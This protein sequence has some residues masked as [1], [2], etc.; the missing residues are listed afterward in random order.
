MSLRSAVLTFIEKCQRGEDFASLLKEMTDLA[1]LLGFDRFSITNLW[2]VEKNLVVPAIKAANYDQDLLA[3]YSALALGLVDPI[4]KRAQVSAN[5][6]RWSDVL[7]SEDGSVDPVVLA[8]YERAG[9]VEGVTIPVFNERF[10]RSIVGFSSSTAVN[11][12]DDDLA[13]LG[14]AIIVFRRSS[15]ARFLDA[16][17]KRKSEVLTAREREVLRWTAAGKSAWEVSAILD[18]SEKTVARH[19]LNIRAKLRATNTVHA[20]AEAIRSR[21]IEL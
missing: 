10:E 19:L 14:L 12:S 15:V 8:Y 2:Q 1:A 17:E 9:I 13:L 7:A 11:I 4:W 16:S 20:V 21:Q 3:E 5:P 18:L 6:F